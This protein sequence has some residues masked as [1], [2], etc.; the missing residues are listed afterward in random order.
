MRRGARIVAVALALS[1]C[2]GLGL[3][4]T[5]EVAPG[6]TISKRRFDAPIDE[7]PFFG[8]ATKTP[9]QLA[10]DRQ[11]VDTVVATPGREPA[12]RGAIAQGWAGIRA[13]DFALAARRFN[14][15]YLLVPTGA[16]AY[17]GFAVVA[18]G[19]F[20]DA[21]LADELFRLA[22]RLKPDDGP[23]QADYARFLLTERRAAAAV[24]LLEAVVRDPRAQAQHWSNLGFAYAQTGRLEEAC[25]ALRTAE[26][27]EPPAEI[28]RDLG[29]LRQI[30][31]C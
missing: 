9:Q 3:A 23:I 27:K 22:L 12:Y 11:F 4:E 15:A 7:Q 24:P 2:P 31:G 26:G 18:I 5:G 19:R 10:A 8:L 13:N 6:L 17:H 14:Q 28:T 25:R 1:F 30:A 16:E 29:A 21:D 20:R